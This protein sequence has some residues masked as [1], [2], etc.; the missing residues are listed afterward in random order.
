MKLLSNRIEDGLVVQISPLTL[1]I[2]EFKALIKRDRGSTGD[3]QGRKKLQAKRDL[4]FVYFFSD[5]ESP[6]TSYA[7]DAREEHLGRDLGYPEGWNLEGDEQLASAVEKYIEINRS[8]HERLLAAAY[9]GVF[10]LIDYFEEV[11]LKKMDSMKR[12]VYSAKDLIANLKGLGPVVENL[13]KLR[14]EAEKHKSRG[15]DVRRGVT[16]SKYNT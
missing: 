15:V 14:E 6:Y 5:L 7:E 16:L 10:K 12:P 8:I 11:D 4:A 1:E 13:E 3:S 9:T 2:G